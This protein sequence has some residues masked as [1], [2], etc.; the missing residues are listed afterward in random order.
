MNCESV[1]AE[2]SLLLYGELSFEREELI[3]QHLEQCE[4]CRGALE[5]ERALHQAVD[6][7]R[8]LPPAFLLPA[9]RRGLFD[10]LATDSRLRRPS[11]WLQR[12]RAVLAPGAAWLRPAGAVALVALGF[13]AARY[14]SGPSLPAG[15]HPAPSDSP[16]ARVRFVEPDAQGR[17]RIVL[18]E[19]RQRVLSG[20]LDEDRIQ[21]LLLA[22]ARDPSDPGLRAETLDVLRTR[23]E[24][25]EVRR[26][27]LYALEHDPNA[28][29]RLKAL[30][31]LKPFAAEPE[32]RK[33][34]SRVLLADDNPGVRAQTIDLLVQTKQIDLV[35]TLQELLRREDNNYIRLRS[36]RALREM[37]ASLDTF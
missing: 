20:R 32:T 23:S 13:F 35:G 18:E 29:V 21:Q 7:E 27:L 4:A 22:A 9:S 15:S 28:G 30:D 36:Q 8:A 37:N 24:S 6:A 1:R 33:T 17:V 34:L 31:A 12:A 26:A 5:R 16:V 10:R 11:G 25:G 3:E 2:L 14:T 19:T